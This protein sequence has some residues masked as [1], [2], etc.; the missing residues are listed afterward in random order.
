M[1]AIPTMSR[2]M[3]TA[4]TTSWMKMN[5]VAAISAIKIPPTV[6]IDMKATTSRLIQH[7]APATSPNTHMCRYMRRVLVRVQWRVDVAAF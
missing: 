7:Y 2:V 5:I 1:S 4:T 3:G 6:C